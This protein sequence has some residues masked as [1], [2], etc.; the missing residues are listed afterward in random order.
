MY[1]YMY[2]DDVVS[3]R[4][5]DG[6]CEGLVER[7]WDVV[8][9]P[10][11][12][13]CR[14]ETQCYTRHEERKG[15]TFRRVWRPAF[16]QAS[17]AGRILNAIWMIMAWRRLAFR[18]DD[19][20]PDVVMVGTDP[21][22]SVLVARKIKRRKPSI[23]IAHWCF[24]LYPE[25]AV[26]DG[27]IQ[28]GSWILNL[29]KRRLRQAYGC[30]DLIVDL[31]DCMRNLISEYDHKARKVTLVPWALYEPAEPVVPD[32][33][34]RKRLFGDADLALLYSGS[35]GRAHSSEEFLE[36]ADS[37]KEMK[38][39]FGFSAR[40]N[41]AEILQ[42]EI[43]KSSANAKFISFVKDNDVDKHLGSADIHMV[44]LRK[45]WTGI[46]VPSKFFGALAFGKPVLFAG[47][48][49]SAVAKWIEQYGVGWVLDKSS[50]S[51][52]AEELK[53]LVA[54][55]NSLKNLQK[56]CHE[57]YHTQ[58][59]KRLIM[60]HWDRELREGLNARPQV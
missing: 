32:E 15:I 36:L 5:Y 43:E 29:L 18:A 48:R 33:S 25:A 40:G 31:G 3:A 30:C 42:S 34:T 45:N 23:S 37:L 52:V 7:G 41:R 24:D 19:R 8:A 11:N 38:I 4:H 2:P 17:A 59:C 55:Q 35:F 26:A 50:I 9:L 6:F 1:H 20:C 44:S 28:P 58:F 22:L 14:D 12:R 53:A 57:L 47:S 27:M 13:G 51:A 46:V 60:D 49:D 10:G 16:R 56:H 54:D 21:V 39:E